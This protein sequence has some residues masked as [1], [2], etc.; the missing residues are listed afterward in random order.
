MQFKTL[1][2]SVLRCL[3]FSKQSPWAIT[4][5]INSTVNI[6]SRFIWMS[7][8]QTVPERQANPPFVLSAELSAV[9][10]PVGPTPHTAP[11]QHRHS[12]VTAPA[13]CPTSDRTHLPSERWQ[14][15]RQRR[16][17]PP[18]RTHAPCQ[19]GPGMW[20]SP[21]DKQATEA[22]TIR[23]CASTT[24]TR[25][26]AC[27]CVCLSPITVGRDQPTDNSFISDSRRSG[28]VFVLR[29]PSARRD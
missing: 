8:C 22:V 13:A 9:L 17:R 7:N 25:K 28:L 2:V 27:V 21:H 19:I 20:T 12:T 11:P 6:F 24:F 26:R 16:I 29:L 3:T 23:T 14:T 1:S 5:K 4:E 18:A 15:P 10:K